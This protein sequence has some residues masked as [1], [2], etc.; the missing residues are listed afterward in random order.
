MAFCDRSPRHPYNSVFSV[1][2]ASCFPA[3]CLCRC[4]FRSPC[5]IPFLI[6]RLILRPIPHLILRTMLI[7]R[8][9]MGIRVIRYQNLMIESAYLGAFVFFC[10]LFVQQT[11]LL[12]VRKCQYRNHPN[13]VNP[14]ETSPFPS[15][16]NGLRMLTKVSL[17]RD[18]IKGSLLTAIANRAGYET[19]CH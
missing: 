3:R 10:C 6:I 16:G 18:T 5:R 14:K 7:H 1:R 17:P 9:C 15:K 4:R 2:P 11:S 13:S 8:M 19:V 12:W